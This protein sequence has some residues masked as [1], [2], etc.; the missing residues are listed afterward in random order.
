MSAA[1]E[2]FGDMCATDSVRGNDGMAN[3]SFGSCG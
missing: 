3:F 1:L 2:L